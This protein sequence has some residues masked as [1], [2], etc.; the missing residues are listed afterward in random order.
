VLKERDGT[1]VYIGEV[2]DVEFGSAIR[3]GAL[4]ANG[5]ESVGGF[6]LK[7]INTNTQATLNVIDEKIDQINGALREGM[8]VSTYYS[9]GELVNKAISTLRD[10][11]LEGAVL[12]LIFLWLFLG[13]LRSTLIVVTVLPLAALGA[14]IGMWFMSLSANLMSLGRLAIGIGM[15]VDGAVVVVEN[16]FRHMEERAEEDISMVRLVGEATREVARPTAF[17]IGIIIVVFL[18]LFTLQ[19]VEGKM[20]APMAYTISFAL[21]SALVLA[22]TFVPAM[23]SLVFSRKTKHGEPRL[24]RWLKAGYRPIIRGA[25]GVPSLVLGL[26][27]VLLVGSLCLFP[28]LGSEFVP[29]LRQ[30]TFFVRLVLPPGAHLGSSIEY[31]KRIQNTLEDFPEVEGMYARVGRAEVG[32]D[33]EQV[34]VVAT[35]INLKNLSE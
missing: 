14:F 16:I 19:G 25:V 31:S 6:I 33:P 3:R 22:F 10:V 13:N 2:A 17:S 27:V 8:K 32:G 7:L 1:P 5:E 20:F 15:M 30:G 18:P 26:A 23:C 12:V 34:N 35:L 4:V 28:Y 9:Q 29:T 24:V 21:I 11:L